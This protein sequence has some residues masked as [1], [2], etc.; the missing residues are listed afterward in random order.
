MP[1]AEKKKGTCFIITPI[2][3]SGTP[4]RRK[5]D[6][7]I[8]EVIEP[9]LSEIGYRV[10]VS[11]RINDSGSVTNAIIKKVYESELV[12][13]NLT[14]NNPNV[15]YEVALRHASAKPIIHITESI[16]DLPFDINDQRT[17][18]YTDDMAGAFQLKSDLQAMIEGIEVNVL[19]SNPVTVALEKKNLVNIPDSAS[20]DFGDMLFLLHDD[21]MQLKKDL[22][23]VK[24]RD[25]RVEYTKTKKQPIL[26]VGHNPSESKL[27][28]DNLLD[29][30]FWQIVK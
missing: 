19:V 24:E 18:E 20:K 2:G 14:G 28:S 29:D 23:V 21:M 13:A 11:H 1:N 26:A 16:S 27:S 5:I 25:N 15:M 22:A 12:I 4:T 30:D 10:E 6:G 3:G 9:V 7:I 17:I 8:N